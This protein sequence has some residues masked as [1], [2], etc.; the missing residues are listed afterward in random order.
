M[1]RLALFASCLLPLVALA[2]WQWIDLAG[3]RVYSDLAPP[4]SVPEK[5]ILKRPPGSAPAAEPITSPQPVP[6]NASAGKAGV[7]DRLVADQQQ[8]AEQSQ[9]ALRKAE[10]AR[11]ASTQLENCQRAK[12]SKKAFDS[13][14]RVSVANEQGE[15]E[16]MDD[17]A[18]MAESKRLQSIIEADCP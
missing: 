4:S 12:R 13:G 9:S 2:Q 15:R 17:A 11:Q 16:I 5:N 14:L 7:L 6:P 18:R 10:Q 1:V 3:R 8:K